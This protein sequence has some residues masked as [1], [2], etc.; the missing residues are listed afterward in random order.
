M[1]LACSG[2]NPDFILYD[3]KDLAKFYAP[4]ASMFNDQKGLILSYRGADQDVMWAGATEDFWLPEPSEMIVRYEGTGDVVFTQGGPVSISNPMNGSI[5]G[6]WELAW[7]VLTKEQQMFILD[8][9]NR[10]TPLLMLPDPLGN[11]STAII[12][13]PPEI[14]PIVGAIGPSQAY[15]ARIRLS[16]LHTQVL[17][18]LPV[19][20]YSSNIFGNYDYPHLSVYVDAQHRMNG[21]YTG[22]I[23]HYF[24]FWPIQGSIA[25]GFLRESESEE[26]ELR[27]SDQ[28]GAYDTIRIGSQISHN[29]HTISGLNG[30]LEQYALGVVVIG[31]DKNGINI[32]IAMT[33][34]GSSSQVINLPQSRLISIHALNI[35]GTAAW[36]PISGRFAWRYPNH[37]GLV[38][39]ML[40]LLLEES[41]LWG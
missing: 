16:V 14:K 33:G 39:K 12:S 23:T 31:Y 15:S 18:I 38:S 19:P 9:Y 41:G 7:D 25:V 5:L 28:M 32:S 8:T 22:T 26:L 30:F 1:F 3:N 34:P 29:N 4:Y 17:D 6:E 20:F 10:K 13:S 2:K 27:Y 11:V 24:Y 36:R 21:F 35:D 37:R 40:D